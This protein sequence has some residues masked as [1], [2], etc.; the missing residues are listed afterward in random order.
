MLLQ[1]M[2]YYERN[3]VATM[4]K[5]MA[6]L[7]ALVLSMSVLAGCQSNPQSKGELSIFTWIDYVPAEVMQS[8]E[9][10][11]GI[12][13]IPSYFS[14]NEEMISKL[15]AQKNTYD[16]I[17]CSDAFIDLMVREGGLVQPIDT[18]KLKN[19]GNISPEYQSKYFDPEN[20]YTIPHAAYAAL[21]AYDTAKS[22]VAIK[23]YADLWNPAL[24]NS[25]VL[26]DDARGVIGFTLQMQGESVN[27]TDAGKL[28]TA[29]EKLMELWPNVRL[30]DA[31]RPHEAFLR[32]DAVAGY[33]FGSQ[34]VA[35]MAEI[36]TLTY[37]Y[38]EEGLTY[39]MDC[40][41]LADG[42]PNKGNA[43]LFLDYILRG[44]VS[45]EIS[46]TINYI[47]C[48]SAATAFLPESFLNDP[49]V[50]IPMEYIES[51]QMYKDVGNAYAAY[52]DIWTE[53]KG[54]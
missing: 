26:L 19:H 50:N 54:Q 4:K 29:K 35:A 12:R 37:V 40:Y 38:P 20:Q 28:N 52:Y 10:E 53:F 7:L 14:T 36:S 39:G 1:I 34:I 49:C 18:G 25:V 47:N 21:L 32:G 2:F 16:L 24:K 48:N 45:A 11:T 13:V 31:D 6:M 17:V 9:E 15:R 51:A 46:A 8:F 41:V 27:E 22:P 44:E 23:G 5:M 3:G 30:L 43:H 42:A 33:M